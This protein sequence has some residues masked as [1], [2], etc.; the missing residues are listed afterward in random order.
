MVS[1]VP[2]LD[3]PRIRDGYATVVD[4]RYLTE[5]EGRRELFGW[6]LR[7]MGGY[8]VRGRRLLEIGSNV[9][10]FLDVARRAGWETRGYEPSRWAVE[11]GRERFGVDLRQGTLE[12]LDEPPRSANAVVLL[13]VLEHLVDPLEGLRRIR[14]LVDDDG[15]LT[16]STVNI[17][18][19]HSRLRNER[20]PW[21]IRPHL[22][23]FT[24][25]TLN[26]MLERAGFRIVEW[27][28]VP[29]TFH[30]SYLA[31]RLGST[32]GPLTPALAG[33]SRLADVRIPVGWLGDV[34]LV[35]ARPVRASDL[36]RI[37]GPAFV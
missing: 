20:W 26:A 32:Y 13:D 8:A 17:S 4:E 2:T 5:E 29:R 34:V 35:T 27:A 18:S 12:Q 3:P 21:L 31:H 28:V 14:G 36:P 1:S 25:R 6:V 11:F 30:L 22:H 24:P 9:G 7:S 15:L 19:L 23:Y 37:A 16:L 33:L 10:L